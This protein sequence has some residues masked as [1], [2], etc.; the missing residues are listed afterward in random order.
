[1]L[2]RT[3]ACITRQSCAPLPLQAANIATA[4]RRLGTLQAERR[5]PGAVLRGAA[6]FAI[7][8]MAK[9]RLRIAQGAV[10]NLRLCVCSTRT[11][12][13]LLPCI[14]H[15]FVLHHTLQ[16]HVSC[17][18]DA[19]FENSMSHGQRLMRLSAHIA[20]VGLGWSC[21]AGTGL[22]VA[23]REEDDSWSPPSALAALSAGWG[24]QARSPC[25]TTCLNY[26]GLHAV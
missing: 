2:A 25:S 14:L 17:C 12:A 3:A 11:P 23:R 7:L 26:N 21:G 5:I 18:G 19:S 15:P 6:G 16:P 13:H 22:V 8:S 4:F 1:M 24:L 20:Q 9:V 10:A